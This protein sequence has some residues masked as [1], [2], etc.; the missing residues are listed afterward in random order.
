MPARVHALLVVRPEGRVA[1]D[2]HLRRTLDALAARGVVH[3]DDELHRRGS[4][5]ADLG[6]GTGV[7]PAAGV[8]RAG[9]RVRALGGGAGLGLKLLS[10]AHMIE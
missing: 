4:L 6:S 10:D 9:R 3:A 1:A 5:R 2:I 7:D 8:D